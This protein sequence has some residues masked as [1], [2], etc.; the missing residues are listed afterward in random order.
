MILFTLDIKKIKEQGKIY[1][2]VT[3]LCILFAIIYESFSHGVISNF[4]I[5]SFAIPLILGCV[6]NYIFYF[7]KIKKL[8]NQ[9]ENRFYNAGIATLTIGSIMEGVLQIYG[10]TNSKIYV[11]LIVGLILL[12][13]SIISY[14]FRKAT[15]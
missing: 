5:Y 7:L 2:I 11:Y 3:L 13:S 9:F 6:V 4:M 12:T 10:T 8:P 14:K 15:R 1:I